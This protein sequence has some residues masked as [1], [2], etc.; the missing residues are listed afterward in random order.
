M[1]YFKDNKNQ[2]YAFESDGSQDAYIPKSLIAITVTE[3]DNLR[4]P[5][6]PTVAEV[7][8]VFVAGIQKRLDDFVKT[9]NY[10]NILSACTYATSTVPKF[11]EEGQHC[12]DLRDQTWASAYQILEDVQLKK[13]PMPASIDDIASRLPVLA[14]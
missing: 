11:A 10:D 8:A 2:V 12:V 6:A 13:I 7:T 5:P 3:A 9:R 1:K 4:K 14:W